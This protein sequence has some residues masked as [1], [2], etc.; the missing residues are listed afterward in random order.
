MGKEFAH[1]T[2]RQVL[3]VEMDPSFRWDDKV[4]GMTKWLG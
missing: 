4:V 3:I 1:P 2:L